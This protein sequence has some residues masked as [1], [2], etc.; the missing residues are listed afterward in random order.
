MF[1]VSTKIIYGN[2]KEKINELKEK[3]ILEG[4][5]LLCTGKHY[6]F[7]NDIKFLNLRVL[8]IHGEPTLDDIKN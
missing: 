7:Y 5:G 3:K 4:Y 6:D 1:H 8:R 2:F